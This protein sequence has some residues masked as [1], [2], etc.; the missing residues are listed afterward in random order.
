MFKRGHY[1]KDYIWYVEVETSHI[2]HA[3]LEDKV[4]IILKNPNKIVQ[5]V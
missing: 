2:Y 3:L 4:D 5:M 1:S